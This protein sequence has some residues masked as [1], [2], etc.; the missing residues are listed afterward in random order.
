MQQIQPNAGEFSHVEV[1]LKHCWDAMC[2][3]GLCS[4]TRQCLRSAEIRMITKRS[5]DDVTE[6]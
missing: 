6:E 4:R 5:F 2:R 1:I 3:D